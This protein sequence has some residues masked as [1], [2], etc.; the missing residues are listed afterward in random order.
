[1]AFDTKPRISFEVEKVLGVSSDG[2][3]RVQWAPAWVSKFHLVGCE[4]LIQEFLQRQ[5]ESEVID[6]QPHLL[7]HEQSWD[8][9]VKELPQTNLCRVDDE[10]TFLHE[11]E[12]SNFDES[13]APDNNVY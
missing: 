9:D 6:T 4:H 10:A 13:L 8:I 3:Y 5:Q 2:T 7:Q 11:T 12:Q 1:M